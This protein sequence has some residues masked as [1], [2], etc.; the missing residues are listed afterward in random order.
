[1]R[2]GE[3][4]VERNK[5]SARDVERALLAQS[6]MG[7]YLGQ[8]LVKLGLVAEQDV[9]H[10]LVDLL[11]VRL[12]AEVDY[13]AEPVEIAQ[14]S[15]SF[16]LSNGVVPVAAPS[17]TSN[18][19]QF[20]SVIPQDEY[21]LKALKMALGEQVDVHLGLEADVANALKLRQDSGED[22]DEDDA[23]SSLGG[24]DDDEFVE[25]LKDLA[26]EAPVI[27]LVNQIIH[28]ALD[29]GASDIHVEPFDGALHLRYRVDGV[30]QSMPD[31]PSLDLA[32]AIASRIKLLA[33]MN[34]AERR[35]PQDGRI[36]T[37][38]KGH[39]LDLRVSTIPTVHGESIV[40]RVLDRESI[41][42][43]L[44][45]MGFS[46]R[47]LESYRHLLAKPHGV[48]L[49]TGPTGSGKTTT[50]YASLATLDA[51]ELKIITVEDPVE[52]QLDG[53]NQIQVQ[54]QIELTFARSLRAILRQDPDIIMIGEMRDGETAQIA[55][56]SALTGH[57]VLSTLHT[58]TAAGA[59]TRLED[60]GIE[61]YLIT[62]SVNGVL[63]QRLVRTL[64]KSCRVAKPVDA[65]EAK[66][67]GLDRFLVEGESQI[68]VPQGCS[69]CKQSGYRGRT[70]IHELFVMDSAMHRAI[71]AG[72]DATLLHE[73]ARKGGMLTLFED[74]LRKVAAGETSLEEVLR[75]TQDQ[76]ESVDVDI[77]S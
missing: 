33:H 23:G 46:A 2:L 22:E 16:L 9:A 50:L 31:A 24:V 70:A 47:T 51:S 69:E 20:V 32:P 37:R 30:I 74:G 5:L 77:A 17:D 54:S 14:L 28:R 25:H 36:M 58:N 42:L 75:V 61:R 18:A 39:E 43:S 52:Y 49:V 53:V 10:A 19:W 56:Q 57:L 4:L 21:I 48:L 60:M 66:R 65:S 44:E 67:L 11:G 63:A 38:V 41:Q 26:S 15:E 6:E 29:L 7:G 72:Y 40:M 1:M 3:W 8:V 76:N 45:S 59:I 68:Y 64:C 27:R 13:P 35:L 34:I 73:E 71:Q 62:S 55:V 12:L